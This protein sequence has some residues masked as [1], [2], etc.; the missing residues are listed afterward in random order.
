MGNNV[1]RANVLCEVMDLG[2]CVIE[3]HSQ[4]GDGMEEVGFK[5]KS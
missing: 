5:G 3:F 2:I 4:D 1:M